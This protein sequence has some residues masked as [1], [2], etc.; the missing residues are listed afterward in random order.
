MTLGFDVKN[1]KK[2]EEAERLNV[3]RELKTNWWAM[4]FLK[5]KRIPLFGICN[6]H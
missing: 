2:F 5:R 4:Q 6:I 1:K 3:N